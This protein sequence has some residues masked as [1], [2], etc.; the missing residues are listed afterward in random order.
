M[1]TT[2][3]YPIR[4]GD[5]RQDWPNIKDQVRDLVEKAG[6]GCTPEEI[7]AF[8][9][10]QKA[11]LWISARGFAVTQVIQNQHT[12]RRELFVWLLHAPNSL[13]EF[14][15]FLIAVGKQGECHE[16]VFETHRLGFERLKEMGDPIAKP[17][18]VG[19]Y[20]V[21]RLLE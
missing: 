1:S 11:D 3:Q 9:R 17:Y 14:H 4:R 16:V 7:Y 20:K 19:T 15:D 2:V 12:T 6:D 21:R 18:R 13:E 10:F 8:C 5:V